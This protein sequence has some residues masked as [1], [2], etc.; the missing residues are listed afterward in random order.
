MHTGKRIP[1]PLVAVLLAAALALS[2][3]A[4]SAK[5]P[6]SPRLKKILVG[7]TAL[8]VEV[9]D[10]LEKQERGLMFRRSLP[11]NE[12]M[13]FVY[14]EPIELSFWMRNTLI[15]LDIAFVGAD[16][17]I[18]N[19]HQAHPLDESVLYRSAGAAKYVIE[20]NRGWFARHGIGPGDKVT[21][22]R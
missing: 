21:L 13:L 20:T 7:K 22:G 2:P 3:G 5:D 16:G 14:R 11:E 6:Q 12:G 10:T 9:A 8:W 4:A 19:I 18:L 17:V 15:P 1:V